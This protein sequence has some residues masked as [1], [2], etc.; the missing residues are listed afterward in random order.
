LNGK[1]AEVLVRSRKIFNPDTESYS[2]YAQGDIGRLQ[3][4]KQFLASFMN[5]IKNINGSQFTSLIPNVVSNFKS[6][7]TDF[8]NHGS[9]QFS[10]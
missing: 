8:G 5:K 4:Q 9:C 1:Q 10:T 7:M 2:S 6:D 3:V